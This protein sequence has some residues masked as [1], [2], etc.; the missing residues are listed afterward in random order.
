GEML[1]DV[2]PNTGQAFFTP[3]GTAV[4]YT[5]RDEAWRPD[6]LWLHRI[7]TPVHDDVQLFHE[8]DERFWMGAGITRSRRYLVIGLGSKITS[9][10]LLIDIAELSSD[11]LSA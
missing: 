11:P 8:P 5:T 4:L 1:D 7:G 10:E 9:E 3:D 2:I 6:T